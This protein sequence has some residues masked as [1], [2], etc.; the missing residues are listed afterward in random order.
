MLWDELN[1]TSLENSTFFDTI[2]WKRQ[3]E[4]FKLDEGT[5]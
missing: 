4:K 5:K 3:K 2:E 1:V